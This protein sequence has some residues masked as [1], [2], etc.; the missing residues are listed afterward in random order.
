MIFFTTQMISTKTIYNNQ[1]TGIIMFMKVS[2][3]CQFH[4]A[5]IAYCLL[6]FLFKFHMIFFVRRTYHAVTQIYFE[7]TPPLRAS[8]VNQTMMFFFNFEIFIFS[9][10]DVPSQNHLSN[11]QTSTL[12]SSTFFFN[13]IF[14]TNGI[15]HST[16]MLAVHPSWTFD[17]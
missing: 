6:Q 5:P 8:H 13:P 16:D 7:D 1:E 10:V 2:G 12:L 4:C 14:S 17:T 15:G 3:C 9:I 11:E